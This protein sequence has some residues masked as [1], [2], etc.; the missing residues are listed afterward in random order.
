MATGANGLRR[1]IVLIPHHATTEVTDG[2]S[3]QAEKEGLSKHGHKHA[4]L[5]YVFANVLFN[6]DTSSFTTIREAYFCSS[7]C[8]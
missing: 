4:Q 3:Q 8:M 7:T 6:M 5:Q 2:L 1:M